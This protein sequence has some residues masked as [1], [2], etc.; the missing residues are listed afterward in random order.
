MSGGAGQ[1]R[2]R[3]LLWMAVAAVLAVGLAV[4]ALTPPPAPKVRKEVG[5]LVAPDFAA[6]AGEVSSITVTTMEET[7]HIVHGADGWVEPERGN[8]KVASGRVDELVHALSGMRFAAPMTRDDKK[9]DRIGLG[10]PKH[11]GTGALVEIGGP[12]GDGLL[13]ILVGFR[14]GRSYV[15]EPD[16]LQAWAV[17]ADG[18]PPLQRGARWL[19]LEF[20]APA[21]GSIREVEVRLAGRPPYRLAPKDPAGA[22]FAMA[23]P[24]DQ[25]R[26]VA[27]FAPALPGQAL[28]HFSPTD[29]A[30]IASLKDAKPVA[31]HLTRLASGLEVTVRAFKVGDRGWAT[32][33]AR[34]EPAAPPE[35]V[36]LAS[37]INARSAG[38]AFALSAND[39]SAF[40]TP[41]EA[42]VEPK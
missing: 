2:R 18:M 28:S 12:S 8:Y 13:K 23:P 14:D 32:V 26:L 1:T 22:Q 21:A 7:Y 36:A 16:D 27:A 4:A 6:K 25:R 15:R 5:S 35:T 40:A 3:A 29:V 17:K 39:W 34:T 10:D 41:L 20:I 38:W 42:I 33:S 24:F 19:D 37:A 31:D 9:F 30:P 11:G